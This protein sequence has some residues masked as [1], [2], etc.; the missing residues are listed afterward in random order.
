MSWEK[1]GQ[2]GGDF[3]ISSLLSDILLYLA[4]SKWVCCS[5]L[6]H[7][8]GMSEQ[9]L[10]RLT[11]QNRSGETYSPIRQNTRQQW[12][13]NAF[14][15]KL[16]SSVAPEEDN[17]LPKVL[18]FHCFLVFCRTGEYISLDLFYYVTLTNQLQGL[19]IGLLSSVLTCSFAT[20]VPVTSWANLFLLFISKE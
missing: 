14:N 17:F 10:V 3:Q 9:L 6:C 18:V 8:G 16:P 19:E 15:R 20:N 13:T 11:K 7:C 4:H 1:W 12:N 5:D 2:V